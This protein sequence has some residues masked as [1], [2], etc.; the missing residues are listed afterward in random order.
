MLTIGLT[1]GIGSGKST[2]ARILQKYGAEIIFADD[3]AKQITE[4]GMPAYDKIIEHFGADIVGEDKKINRKKLADI[5]FSNKDEL[6]RLNEIT[7][8]IVAEVII[9]LVDEYRDSGRELVVVEAIVPI[10]HGFLDVVDTVWVVLAEESVR[11]DRVMKRSGLTY[12]E[13]KKRIQSQMP[14]EMYIS[15]ADKIIYNDGTLKELEEK[16][17]GLL[18]DE[19]NSP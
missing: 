3:V 7:H 5:V 9:K 11:I 16:V 8:S 13:A 1:G 6:L 17:W 10:E 2:V 18:S 4:P 12:E 14:D 19:K 15:I